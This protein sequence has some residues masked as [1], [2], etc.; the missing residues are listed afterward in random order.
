MLVLSGGGDEGVDWTTPYVLSGPESSPKF[1]WVTTHSQDN[2]SLI[3]KGTTQQGPII[4]FEKYQ[5]AGKRL[6]VEAE[7]QPV[8]Q[9]AACKILGMLHGFKR[10]DDNAST[11]FVRLHM[12]R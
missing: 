8:S 9:T 4:L 1:G 11:C 3:T 7:E 6:E 5:A 2:G 12:F 10:K